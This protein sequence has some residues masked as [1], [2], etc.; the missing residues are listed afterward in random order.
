MRKNKFLNVLT[1]LAAVGLTVLTMLLNTFG[2]YFFYHA[3]AEND[4]AKVASE[5]RAYEDITPVE[6][7]S[8]AAAD[9]GDVMLIPLG[10]TFGIKLY[11]DGIIVTSLAEIY[12]N[13]TT[14]CPAKDAGI[15]VGDYIVAI[16][17]KEIE[18]NKH[19]IDLLSQAIGGDIVLTI[20]R[21]EEIFT[22]TLVPV[23]DGTA[24]RCGMWVRDSAAGI[25]TLTFANPETNSFA[26]L[27]HGI[28]DIDTKQLL[29]LGGG[30]PA[31][32][33]I[34]DIVKGEKSNPGKINGFFSDTTSL[35][36]L[37]DNNETGIYGKLNEIPSTNAIPLARADEVVAGSAQVLTSI[38]NNGPQLFS[39][40]IEQLS[41]SKKQT[42]KNLVIRITDPRLLE[43]TGG[44]IQGMSG[45][46][47]LQNGKLA[48]AITHVFIDDPKRGYGIFAETMYKNS[49]NNF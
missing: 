41:T 21:N 48:A 3:F 11:T 29:S 5:F 31:P 47:V 30:E 18:N 2:T 45:T 43:L 8:V 16:G 28:C 36:V 35:G 15:Q 6:H 27:G 14:C 17:D 10:N 38:D 9:L 4:T 49:Q 12:A 37:F 26:G 7:T 19:F 22:T 20:H 42:T 33:T 13:G 23:Y 39:A 1:G 40:E 34:C 44:I 32:I 25:G 46:P 24:F